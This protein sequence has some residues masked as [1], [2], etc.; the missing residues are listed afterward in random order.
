MA[1]TVIQSLEI[2]LALLN[3]YIAGGQ[4]FGES[5]L[6]ITHFRYDTS[7]MPG[8]VLHIG[9]II[10]FKMEH[11]IVAMQQAKANMKPRL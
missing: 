5:K 1:T 4:L 6:I 9:I 11:Q 2:G 10:N 3:E 8:F 7:C